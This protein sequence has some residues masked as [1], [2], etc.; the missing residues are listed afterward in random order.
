VS[1]T[2][3]RIESLASDVYTPGEYN[4]IWTPGPQVSSGIYL[5]R[6]EVRKNGLS[7]PQVVTKRC[8]LIR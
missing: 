3:T 4:F 2:G 5:I 8:I 1:I 6:L 7:K